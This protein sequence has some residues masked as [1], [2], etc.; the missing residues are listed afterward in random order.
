[1]NTKHQDQGTEFTSDHLREVDCDDCCQ[2][3]R[4][5]AADL[6]D[7]KDDKITF[8][9]AARQECE[10]QFQE[11]LNDNIRLQAR[12]EVLEGEEKQCACTKRMLV[13]LDEHAQQTAQ[14]DVHYSCSCVP[15]TEQEGEA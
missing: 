7:T 3:V 2:E 4:W 11:K 5:K 1:M 14:S 6:L 10:R 15:A 13:S 8:L 12:I 9:S